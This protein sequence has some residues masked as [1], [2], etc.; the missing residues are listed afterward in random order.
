[1]LKSIFTNKKKDSEFLELTLKERSKPPIKKEL[2]VNKDEYSSIV[3]SN[4]KGDII[5]EIDKAYIEKES[6]DI[7]SY[8]YIEIDYKDEVGLLIDTEK[9]LLK[10]EEK[11]DELLAKTMEKKETKSAGL[12]HLSIEESLEQLIKDKMESP[13]G[14]EKE[15]AHHTE[16]MRNCTM[17]EKARY[18]VEESI[19]KIILSSSAMKR[20]ELDVDNL[21]KKIYA[22]LYGMGVLQ[23]L[24]D[25][26]S[27]GEIMVNAYEKPFSCK[28]YYIQ[29]GLKHEYEKTFSSISDVKQIFN[30]VVNYSKKELNSIENAMIEATRPNKDRINISIP[31]ASE[32]YS[33]N[34][35]KFTNFTPTPEM[36]LKSGTV[37]EEIQDFLELLIRG[38]VNIGIGGG[39][40]TG[41]TV[42]INYLLGFTDKV[43]RKTVIA[44]V[45]EMDI[46][47]VL[48][49]HDVVILNVDDSKGFTFDKQMVFA[50]RTTAN[51]VVIPE[52]RGK[53]F[54]QVH[55]ANL[56]IQGNLFTA[57]ANSDN[58]FLNM[59]TNM[60]LSSPEA[61]NE[62]SEV[63]RNKIASGLHFV[64]V[65]RKINGK[66]RIKSISELMLNK[67]HE[68]IGMNPIYEWEY[69]LANPLQGRY[70]RTG[71]KLTDRTKRYLNENGV[72]MEDI[73]DY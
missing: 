14:T 53:E 19:R 52:S 9:I 63:V 23:E 31:G 4:D 50:L 46:D 72:P 44:S 13:T 29:H 61:G 69:D 15:Q 40:G 22:K 11:Q 42:F 5:A 30:R 12:Q 38:H 36:M 39:M 27:I 55:E 66:I 26:L 17:D 34:I 60:Y 64:I 67:K 16:M 18:Y 43:E 1:M 10:E 20:E 68:F 6:I 48:A 37:N 65:M 45:P 71:N 41:K 49:G 73:S 56:K 35:R 3:I 33:M 21:V 24:D 47:R 59:C 51:R 70:V 2:S 62:S 8:F 58:G 57:H 25:D 28:I 54:I 32:S 7:T